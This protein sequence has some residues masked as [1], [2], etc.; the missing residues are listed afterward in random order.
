MKRSLKLCSHFPSTAKRICPPKQPAFLD[1][2][3]LFSTSLRKLYADVV[4]TKDAQDTRERVVILGS[5]WAGKLGETL[6]NT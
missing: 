2:T 1:G 5:G 4:D 3:R 6:R